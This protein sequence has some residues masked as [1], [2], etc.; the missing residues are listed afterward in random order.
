MSPYTTPRT[1]SHRPV[2]E[3]ECFELDSVSAAVKSGLARGAE[4]LRRSCHV[5]PR[6]RPPWIGRLRSHMTTVK[7]AGHG[8]GKRRGSALKPA[9]RLCLLDLH[10][11]GQAPEGRRRARPFEICPLVVQQ[12]GPTVTS[13][14]PCR[15]LLFHHQNEWF[16]GP[17][18]LAEVQEAEPP[19]RGQGGKPHRF[20]HPQTPGPSGGVF[21]A[22]A[23]LHI[24]YLDVVLAIRPA[25]LRRDIA[26]T[27]VSGA[28]LAD[29]PA[30]GD[31]AAIRPW[32]HRDRPGWR[33]DGT[34]RRRDWPRQGRRAT[35]GLA[36]IGSR[37]GAGATPLARAGAACAWAT[38]GSAPSPS[39]T[40]LGSGGNVGPSTRRTT[41][42]RI[43]AA[44]GSR[45]MGDGRAGRS[46]L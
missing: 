37:A 20:R 3:V 45:R 41:V 9:R 42:R 32:R 27:E 22:V 18:P 15:P 16:Q 29:R 19:G 46:S 26:E 43:G 23:D 14:G 38:M 2:E 4:P 13:H 7:G 11:S 24:G 1:A 5:P 44:S 8:G 35:I 34:R 39:A 30:A 33:S 6:G 31:H 25:G 28:R 40:A 36:I 12:E 21:A 10:P 17:L